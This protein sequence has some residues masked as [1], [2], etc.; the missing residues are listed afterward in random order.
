MLSIQCRFRLREKR[1][2]GLRLKRLCGLPGHP[3]VAEAPRHRFPPQDC[4]GWRGRGFSFS[5]HAIGR[6]SF[7]LCLVLLSVLR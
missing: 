6:G 5:G 3:N 4:G 7:L 2:P 1:R